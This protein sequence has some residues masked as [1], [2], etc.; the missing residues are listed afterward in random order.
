[1]LSAKNAQ[2]EQVSNSNQENADTDTLPLNNFQ[3]EKQRPVLT[4]DMLKSCLNLN[5][6]KLKLDH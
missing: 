6:K 2:E 5:E 1:M 3:P 4:L